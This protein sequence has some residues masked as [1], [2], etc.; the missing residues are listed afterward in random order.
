MRRLSH[1]NPTEAVL[2]F[3]PHLSWAIL[4]D[5]GLSCNLGSQIVPLALEFLNETPQPGQFQSKIRKECGRRAL[6]RPIRFLSQRQ[7]TTLRLEDPIF[8]EG[9]LAFSTVSLALSTS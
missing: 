1:P 6:C 3:S 9:H 2:R 5:N 8:L 4:C 7:E